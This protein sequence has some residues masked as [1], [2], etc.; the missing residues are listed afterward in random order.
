MVDARLVNRVIA[1]SLGDDAGPG[2]RE[3]IGLSAEVTEEGNIIGGAIVGIACRYSRATIGDLA[4][5]I[6]E[7]VPYTRGATI[8]INGAFDLVSVMLLAQ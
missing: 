7:G 5:D 6:A 8:F 4:R 1:A 3:T 2:E